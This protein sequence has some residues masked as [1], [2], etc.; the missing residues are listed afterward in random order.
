M[1]YETQHSVCIIQYIN[2]ILFY[3]FSNMCKGTQGNLED[4]E[5]F[6]CAVSNITLY[7]KQPKGIFK[8]KNSPYINFPSPKYLH[9]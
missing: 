4:K 8:L 1:L 3:I 7:F 9:P 5:A 2:K 6:F